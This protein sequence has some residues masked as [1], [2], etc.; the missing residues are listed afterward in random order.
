MKD[1]PIR[2]SNSSQSIILKTPPPKKKHTAHYCQP[3][4][5]IYCILLEHL[6]QSSGRFPAYSPPT[7]SAIKPSFIDT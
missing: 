6:N 4:N 5:N 1:T 7:G 3:L 2:G